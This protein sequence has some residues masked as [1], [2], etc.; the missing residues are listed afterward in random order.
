[1]K[2]PLFH[3]H[4]LFS[5]FK[6]FDINRPLSEE[7]INTHLPQ[8]KR[9]PCP[10]WYQATAIKMNSTYLE[11]M[12]LMFS[13]KGFVTAA[14]LPLF[15]IVFYVLLHVVWDTITGQGPSREPLHSPPF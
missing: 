13:V 4:P 14:F 12:D 10:P 9:S 2:R 8:N 15:L 7:E 11:C 1:M 5:L 3:S 6:K